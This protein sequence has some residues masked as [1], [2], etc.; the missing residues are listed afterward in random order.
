MPAG[1]PRPVELFEPA[2]RHFDGQIN[3]LAK[4]QEVYVF[5][6]GAIVRQVAARLA[7][8]PYRGALG[9][10]ALCGSNQE[11]VFHIESKFHSNR[12]AVGAQARGFDGG[13]LT[14]GL[15]VS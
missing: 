2:Q 5:A 10:L 4:R 14:N 6:D 3:R 11:I 7:H 15:P 9:A 13:R 12:R 8:H 1:A